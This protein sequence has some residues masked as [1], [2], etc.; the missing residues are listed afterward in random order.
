MLFIDTTYRQ[1]CLRSQVAAESRADR[2]ERENARLRCMLH[3]AVGRLRY[4]HQVLNTAT[5][6]TRRHHWHALIAALPTLHYIR[7]DLDVFAEEK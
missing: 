7:E 6:R 1:Q 5:P 4:I 3:D 2:L